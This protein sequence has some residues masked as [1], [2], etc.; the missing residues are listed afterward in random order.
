MVQNELLP[1][2][3]T[4][5]S[6][7]KPALPPSSRPRASKRIDKRKGR[8]E[9]IGKSLDLRKGRPE[10]RHLG[11]IGVDGEG[12]KDADGYERYWLLRVGDEEIESPPGERL[13]TEQCLDFLFNCR[14][15]GYFL[16]GFAL[17]YDVDHI[18]RDLPDEQF[19]S[20]RT[21]KDGAWWWGKN[22]KYQ[23]KR[24]KSKFLQVTRFPHGPGK[25]QKITLYDSFS[26]FQSSFHKALTDWQ[27]GS[28]EELAFIAEMKAL[29]GDFA[30]V[31]QARIKSYNELECRLLSDLMVKFDATIQEAIGVRLRAWHGPGAL[32]KATLKAK[33]IAPAIKE[34]QD[35]VLPPKFTDAVCRAFFGGWFQL[36]KV[37]HFGECRQIDINS[38]YPDQTRNLP[39]LGGTVS[40][41][42]QYDPNAYAVWHVTW[43]VE[44]KVERGASV[45]VSVLN[46]FPY[47]SKD[48]RITRPPW[49]NGW[50]WQ[51][52]VRLALKLYGDAITVVEGWVYTPPTEERPFEEL[53]NDLYNTRLSLGKKTAGMPIK[54]FLNSIYGVLAQSPIH[55]EKALGC[56]MWAGMIT[57]G[58]RAKLYEVAMR[59]PDDAI[60]AATD[61]LLTEA[62]ADLPYS[63]QLGEWDQDEYSSAAVY[64]PGIYKL[65]GEKPKVKARGVRTEEPLD[66]SAL[67]TEWA[68]KG[69]EGALTVDTKERYVTR[70]LA[71]HWGHTPYR[72]VKEQRTITLHPGNGFI[73]NPGADPV[74]ESRLWATYDL[75]GEQ[76]YRR[77]V[78]APYDK[79]APIT[80]AIRDTM[81]LLKEEEI[82]EDD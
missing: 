54:L 76:V 30:S 20:A 35:A 82:Y 24:V 39:A 44:P 6:Y 57:S 18:L 23:I 56:L 28:E 60:Y 61:G 33:G 69:C 79:H 74:G 12:D 2:L 37:G 59:N 7:S 81:A 13:T 55:G 43:N 42:T 40:H 5:P 41:T 66:W 65:D 14:K 1:L 72:W 26:F 53:V 34:W 46:P 45:K 4:S 77:V 64:Q 29:R 38:A 10:R 51:D 27:I 52:E 78:S 62:I 67:A 68:L 25:G 3:P 9:R 16:V 19:T 31:D 58:T 32:A 36:F 21:E 73:A 22:Y 50:Y 11:F 48:G 63:K 8:P 15:P 80:S 49:G 47:R 17:N 71:I 75:F 70:D